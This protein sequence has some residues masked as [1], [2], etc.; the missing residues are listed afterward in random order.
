MIDMFK[1]DVTKM[2]SLSRASAAT[3]LLFN[4]AYAAYSVYKTGLMA[5]IGNNWL[6]LALAL[7][8]MN[9]GASTYKE[10]KIGGNSINESNKDN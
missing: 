4:F 10:V 7:Y 2:W 8:S 5:D 6:L 1:D 9:K 3:V